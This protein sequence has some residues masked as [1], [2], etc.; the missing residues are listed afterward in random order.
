[1]SLS[2]IPLILLEEEWQLRQ[3]NIFQKEILKEVHWWHSLQNIFHI[4]DCLR[5]NAKMKY[6]ILLFT[7]MAMGMSTLKKGLAYSFDLSSDIQVLIELN[8]STNSY[9]VPHFTELGNIEKVT[10][11]IQNNT[12]QQCEEG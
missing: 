2:N 1:M 5:E 12:M 3:K 11:S 10:K 4:P 8:A 7:T 9:R 6:V